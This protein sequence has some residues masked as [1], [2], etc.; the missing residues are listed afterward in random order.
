MS[1]LMLPAALAGTF[2]AVA[3]LVSTAALGAADR[4]RALRVLA[5]QVQ[6]LHTNVREVELARPLTDRLVTPALQRL[7]GLA[8]ALTPSG[9]RRRLEHKLVL[10]GSPAGWD[11]E[12]FVAVKL[13]GLFVGIAF[14][15]LVAA[16]GSPGGGAIV[17][18]TALA[19]FFGFFLPDAVLSMYTR[20]RQDRIR[21]AV[22]DTLD[23]LTIM[24]E[25]GLGFDAALAHVARDV[26][27]P[28]SQEIGRT[29]REM[30]L[31]VTRTDALRNLATR[32]DV[33]DLN[34]FVL[35]LVQADVFG[36][37]IVNVMRAQAGEMRRKRRQRAEA[38]AMK[39]PVKILFPTIF[40]VMPSIF[41]V[42]LGPA[43]IRIAQQFFGGAGL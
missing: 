34:G 13:L 22:P 35:A 17:L 14:V 3:L 11:A 41:V 43:V 30:H 5:R 16:V 38:K 33:E 37:S 12:R 8:A 42:V 18:L 25:A 15:V 31:G 9:T 7:G 6:P 21:S 36:V 1:E 28:L 26:P 19:V 24:V 2:A 4:R 23:L 27:G 39:L 20:Q 10:A 40:C 29:L 32:T